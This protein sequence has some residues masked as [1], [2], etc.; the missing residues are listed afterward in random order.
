MPIFDFECKICG[1]VDEKI[2]SISG[3]PSEP[4]PKCGSFELRKLFPDVLNFSGMQGMP[5][6]DRKF[7]KSMKDKNIR[8]KKRAEEKKKD[9]ETVHRRGNLLEI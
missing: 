9:G 3:I 1:C 4:C 8:L 5:T 2:V 6:W 7:S